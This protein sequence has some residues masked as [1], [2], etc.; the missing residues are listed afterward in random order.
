MRFSGCGIDFA[1]AKKGK[2]NKS[3]NGLFGVA[4]RDDYSYY[5]PLKLKIR[6]EGGL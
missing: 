2:I 3:I 6:L 1:A 4:I 5:F